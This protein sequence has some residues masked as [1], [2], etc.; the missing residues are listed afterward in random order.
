M[1]YE[2]IGRTRKEQIA[3]EA[4]KMVR[5]HIAQSVPVQDCP[6]KRQRAI[7]DKEEI[8]KLTIAKLGGNEGIQTTVTA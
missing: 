6:L 4:A 1:S 8:M 7:W 3:G 5:Q 2:Q